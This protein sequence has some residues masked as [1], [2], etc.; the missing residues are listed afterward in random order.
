MKLHGEDISQD[1][2]YQLNQRDPNGQKYASR[3]EVSLFLLLLLVILLLRAFNF[4]YLY[5][6]YPN[7]GY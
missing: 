6:D 4:L 5:E 2:H 7:S 3:M 1:V